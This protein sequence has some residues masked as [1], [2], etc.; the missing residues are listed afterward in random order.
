VAEPEYRLPSYD[1]TAP[2]FPD[3]LHFVWNL[4]G[5]LDNGDDY[6]TM[7]VVDRSGRTVKVLAILYSPENMK[8]AETHNKS[9]CTPTAV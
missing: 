3:L 1:E 2:R 7:E 5:K 8:K 6:Q 9:V 4:G